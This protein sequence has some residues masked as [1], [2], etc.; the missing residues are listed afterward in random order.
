MGLGCGVQVFG[1]CGEESGSWT[2]GHPPWGLQEPLC[3][4]GPT[5]WCIIQEKKLWLHIPDL[6][7][8]NDSNKPQKLFI[9]P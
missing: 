1:G 8:R 5:G 9:E 4:D 3:L 6:L 2:Q 7:V